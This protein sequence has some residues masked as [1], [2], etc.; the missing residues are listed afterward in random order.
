MSSACLEAVC[1]VNPHRICYLQLSFTLDGLLQM[2][3]LATK[4]KASFGMSSSPS[5]W[6]SGPMGKGIKLCDNDI[7]PIG[8]ASADDLGDL[9]GVSS[10]CRPDAIPTSEC[11]V[12]SF[13]CKPA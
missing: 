11:R 2:Q 5:A 13:D 12:E 4:L 1:L 7:G 8:K 6:T 10:L 9:G 3:K